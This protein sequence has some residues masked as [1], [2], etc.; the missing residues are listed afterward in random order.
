MT[1]HIYVGMILKNQRNKIHLS[2]QLILTLLVLRRLD[3]LEV[4]RMQ[5]HMAVGSSEERSLLGL[6]SNALN[7]GRLW[8]VTP[9]VKSNILQNS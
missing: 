2:V 3:I 9:A 6:F 4:L 1:I 7:G 8:E 5:S